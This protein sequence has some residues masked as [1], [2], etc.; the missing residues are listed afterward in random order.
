M[1]PVQPPYRNENGDVY[2][3]HCDVHLPSSS[4][5]PSFIAGKKRT[6]RACHR[7]VSM[8]STPE[9]KLLNAVRARLRNR[10]RP[11]LCKTWQIEDIVALLSGRDPGAVRV[12][13]RDAGDFT[14]DNAKVV[15][16]VLP[17]L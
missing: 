16:R 3:R 13:P 11:E 17:I 14:A 4:F 5:Y 6:C 8:N 10:G 9:G 7:K 15:P 2:C 1:R 12:V